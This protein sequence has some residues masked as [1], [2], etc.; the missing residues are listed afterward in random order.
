MPTQEITNGP[1]YALYKLSYGFGDE[2]SDKDEMVIVWAPDE[3]TAR[4]LANKALDSEAFTDGTPVEVTVI[5]LDPAK[6]KVVYQ[7]FWYA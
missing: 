4:N 5:A 3:A 6:P 2:T 1:Q 7:D